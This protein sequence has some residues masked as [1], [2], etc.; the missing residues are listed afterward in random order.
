MTETQSRVETIP[1]QRIHINPDNPRKEAGDVTGLAK[2]IDGNGLLHHLLVIPAPQFGPDHVMIEDGYCRFV[3]ARA[4]KVKELDCI[5]RYPGP[6][7][8]LAFRAL[9]TGLITDEHKTPLSAM[10]RA[11]A[12]GRLRDEFSMTQERIGEQL[13][14]TSGTIGRYLSL[15]ELA[16]K[17]QQ[18]VR[19]GTLTV[20]RAVQA[21]QQVRAKQRKQKGQKPVNVGWEPDHFSKHH[22]L[23]RKAAIMC[24]A[25]E[26]S[27][28]RRMGGACGDCWETVIRADQDKI[29]R[30]LLSDAGMEL[31]PVMLA[32]PISSNGAIRA[33]GVKG[34]RLKWDMTSNMAESQQNTVTSLT[35]SL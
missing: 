13:S 29:F 18:K 28:R 33:N 25:R 34:A 12:Y 16:D 1:L 6:D 24:E 17:A 31:P 5:V 21:V 8:D 11:K 7:E 35:T 3:A 10:D 32:V 9:I 2:S 15:L 30:A 14:L 27:G 23:A 19:D 26:H 4:Q 20:E 22:I